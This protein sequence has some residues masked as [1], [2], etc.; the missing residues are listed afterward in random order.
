MACPPRENALIID[1]LSS[2]YGR[3]C[4]A[5]GGTPILAG[6]GHPLPDPTPTPPVRG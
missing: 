3:L 1:R 5:D 2:P 6:W 4:P